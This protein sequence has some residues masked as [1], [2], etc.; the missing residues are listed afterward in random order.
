[1][2]P[3][4]NM[5]APLL[6][7]ICAVLIKQATIEVVQ[8]AGLLG[9][10]FS[11]LESLEDIIKCSAVSKT[12]LLV[13]GNLRPASL[14]IPGA[15]SQLDD[16]GMVQVLRWVQHK[17]QLGQMQ[18]VPSLLDAPSNFDEAIFLCL[19]HTAPKAAVVAPTHLQCVD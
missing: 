7:I 11:H 19:I 16:K 4:L 15:S 14:I 3:Q 18:V 1:M 2:S 10:V 9:A 17:Q 13:S 6:S 8:E 5:L 12:W